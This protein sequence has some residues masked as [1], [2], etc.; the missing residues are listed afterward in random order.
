MLLK[1]ECLH[2]LREEGEDQHYLR[3]GGEARKREAPG[4]FPRMPITSTGALAHGALSSLEIVGLFSM[5]RPSSLLLSAPRTSWS[6]EHVWVPVSR[7]PCTLSVGVRTVLGR[8]C[9]WLRGILEALA[10]PG[11]QTACALPSCHSSGPG[12]PPCPLPQDRTCMP[13]L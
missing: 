1:L 5:L 7:V 12:P 11:T 8:V 13:S 9:T 2:R 6:P 10:F 4:S 3:V